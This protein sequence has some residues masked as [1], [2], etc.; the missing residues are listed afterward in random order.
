MSCNIDLSKFLSEPN[1]IIEKLYEEGTLSILTKEEFYNLP[2]NEKYI[3]KQLYNALPA[4]EKRKINKESRDEHIR[5]FNE[6][7]EEV[8]I[9]INKQKTYDEEIHEED[10]KASFYNF[11]LNKNNLNNNNNV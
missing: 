6:N 11:P 5:K 10:P 7:Q 8:Q 1:N 9:I 4:E 2:L 3:E